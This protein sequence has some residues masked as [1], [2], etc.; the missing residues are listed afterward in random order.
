VENLFY[1]LVG[2]GRNPFVEILF[3]GEMVTLS[4]GVVVIL[5]FAAYIQCSC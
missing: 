4:Y 5:F 1:V 2:K 3:L